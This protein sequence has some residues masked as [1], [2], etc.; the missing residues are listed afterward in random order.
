MKLKFFEIYHWKQSLTYILYNFIIHNTNPYFLFNYQ[1][2]SPE[3]NHNMI[4]FGFIADIQSI[5]FKILYKTVIWDWS[6]IIDYC[7]TG[8]IGWRTGP[9]TLGP[10]H[11]HCVHIVVLNCFTCLIGFYSTLK[12]H[13][14]ANGIH[15]NKGSED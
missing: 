9:T 1:G 6:Q 8:P 3:L 13:I 10:V 14:L 11:R 7:G 15:L 4:I 5:I 2:T 12:D